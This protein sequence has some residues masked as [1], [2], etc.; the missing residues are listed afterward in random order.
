MSENELPRTEMDEY[1]N[2]AGGAKWVKNLS[3]LENMLA[4]ISRH[5][6]ASLSLENVTQVLDIGCGGGRVSA[7]VAD[8]LGG[9]GEILAADISET[10]LASATVARK[11]TT[12]LSFM[13]CDAETYAFE[14]DSFDLIIS[15]FGVMFFSTP[16][17][18]FKNIHSALRKNGRLNFV[19][20]QS[21]HENPWMKTAASAAFEI[22][23]RPPSPEPGE[24]GPFSL[25]DKELLVGILS[26]A[27]FKSIQAKPISEALDLGTVD[28]AVSLMTDM[29]PSAKPIAE[30]SPENRQ[31]AV[32]KIREAMQANETSAGRV[33]LKG[34]FWLVTAQA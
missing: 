25:A 4:P 7:Q 21:I 6:V 8:K 12:N 19:C 15:Q 22:L 24:P 1:W 11:E 14:P 26:S 10:I 32:A 2:E 3:H 18:A 16:V 33:K 5:L 17:N 20:W 30:A 31:Q 28:Q 27:G 9:S 34:S 29:G 13:H 23:E